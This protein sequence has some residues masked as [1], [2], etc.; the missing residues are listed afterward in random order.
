M[1]RLYFW[2]LANGVIALAIRGGFWFG[3]AASAVRPSPLFGLIAVA[4]VAIFWGAFRL[5]RKAKGF[6]LSE[7]KGSDLVARRTTGFTGSSVRKQSARPPRSA[8]AS[9]CGASI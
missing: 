7:A 9:L 1:D 3:V 6:H 8:S 2:S 5:R 4:E